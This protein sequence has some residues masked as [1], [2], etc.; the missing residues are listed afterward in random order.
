[1]ESLFGS[2]F[3]SETLNIAVAKLSARR[4]S[5]QDLEKALLLASKKQ[6]RVV[7]WNA[8]SED[9]KA[10]QQVA[11]KSGHFCASKVTYR[12]LLNESLIS[13]LGHST[14]AHDI[15]EFEAGKPSS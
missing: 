11:T 6:Y 7:F 15:K 3:D 14:A 9:S 10:L 12:F 2:E 4:L 1:M 13:A 5:E 8:L